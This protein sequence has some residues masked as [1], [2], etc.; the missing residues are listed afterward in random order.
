MEP[1]TLSVPHSFSNATQ[2][3]HNPF[4]PVSPSRAA[5]Q[6]CRQRRRLRSRLADT[7]EG[8]MW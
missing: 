3:Q 5:S 6:D 7:V 8:W 4:T 1:L 2:P